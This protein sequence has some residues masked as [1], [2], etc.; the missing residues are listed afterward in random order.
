M[1]IVLLHRAEE[2]S[3]NNVEKDAL[4]LEAVGAVLQGRGDE[5]SHL[6]EEE[7]SAEALAPF[8]AVISMARRFPSLMLLEKSGKRVINVPRGVRCALSRETTLD[9][10]SASGVPVPPYWVH[11][12]V[13]DE[14]FL[15]ERRL[16][17]LLPGWVKGMHP[18]GVHA[19][20]V[21]FVSDAMAADSRVIQLVAEGYTDIV[22]TRH[23]P[24]FVVKV[25]C[26]DGKMIHWMLPQQSGYTK[27][28]DEIHN[29]APSR[30]EEVDV[31]QLEQLSE[32]IGEAIQLQFFGFDAIVSA[33]GKVYVIDVNDAPSFSS[34]RQLAAEKIV[35]LL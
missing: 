8:D 17:A 2:F 18:R 1:K 25:Y 31:R 7:L 14:M 21:S 13:R 26:V 33:P 19:G 11:D 6:R 24:G 3:P 9:L 30:K 28:G 10:L 15:C 35:K 27:F 20:D 34:C 16:H 29:D 5:V 12:P 32:R 22:V 23:E 4:L